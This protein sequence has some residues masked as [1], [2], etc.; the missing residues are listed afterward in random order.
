MKEK[1]VKSIVN[2]VSVL[3]NAVVKID[4]VTLDYDEVFCKLSKK[5][6]NLAVAVFCLFNQK[7]SQELYS[8]RK[9]Q[10]EELISS[11]SNVKS[12][13]PENGI[14]TSHYD[15]KRV[16]GLSGN[17]RVTAKAYKKYLTQLKKF[18]FS[19]RY[20][21]QTLM[22][23]D[24]DKT[25]KMT[26]YV[27]VFG[28]I[29]DIDGGDS[30]VVPLMDEA[31]H[32]FDNF[33]PG[34]AFTIFALQRFESLNSAY[35]KILFLKLILYK[36]KN[37][38]EASKEDIIRIFGL[39]GGTKKNPNTPLYNFM[40]ILP[41]IC[42]EVENTGVFSNVRYVVV[43]GNVKGHSAIKKLRFLA[44]RKIALTKS[45]VSHK[46][47]VITVATWSVS[48]ET[49]IDPKTSLPGIV[50]KKIL[51]KRNI[52]CP[53]CGGKVACW[54]DKENKQYYFCCENSKW[55]KNKL[56]NDMTGNGTCEFFASTNKPESFRT[57]CGEAY[58]R[59]IDWLL[60]NTTWQ[61]E[62]YHV[63]KEYIG[64]T[65]QFKYVGNYL[66]PQMSA[67][68]MIIDNKKIS[69]NDDPFPIE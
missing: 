5:E 14:V 10:F 22:T 61:D 51:K 58:Q 33:F 16:A 27:T 12:K 17:N 2:D 29:I 38:W 26:T 20:P 57:N 66:T 11:T 63:E 60:D 18:L 40:K 62:E 15:L 56:G 48:K 41:K 47:D 28:N 69:D 7:E 9:A 23:G 49:E 19:A 64:K 54:A 36:N 21:I 35:A 34:Q 53:H 43:K 30:L 8:K 25:H 39:T 45:S 65:D 24:D 1:N 67:H 50:E 44:T 32:V 52:K 46:P 3:D 59:I 13:L 37:G 42:D 4:S 6:M 31:V 55:W 68:N